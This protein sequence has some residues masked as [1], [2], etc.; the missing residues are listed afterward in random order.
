MLRAYYGAEGTT[1]EASDFH[2]LSDLIR[3]GSGKK[4]PLN[5]IERQKIIQALRETRGNRKAAAQ[6]IGIARS[7]LHY[8]IN[9]YEIK[10][11]EVF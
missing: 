7:T 11:E 8:K 4:N 3:K 6:N 9:L 5:Q 1:L 10:D 2:F